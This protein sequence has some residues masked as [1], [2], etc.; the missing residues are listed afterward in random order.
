MRPAGPGI[1]VFGG[2]ALGTYLATLL[3]GSGADVRLVR[4][5]ASSGESFTV[6]TGQG[7]RVLPATRI[8]GIGHPPPDGFDLAVIAV[9]RFDSLQLT[10]QLGPWLAA[11]AAVLTVQNGLDA[12]L[13]FGAC[14]ASAFPGIAYASVHRN[15]SEVLHAGAEAR[16]I[17]PRHSQ[18]HS[19]VRVFAATLRA[20]GASVEFVQDIDRALWRK[21]AFVASYGGVCAASGRCAGEVRA[22]PD[23][24]L[25]VRLA[26]VEAAEIA[27]ASGSG[28]GH[29]SSLLDA[30][31]QLP[32]A[33]RPSMLV[34]M[35][36][37]RRL[38]TAW[39]S[40]TLIERGAK[41]GVRSPVHDWIA[42]LLGASGPLRQFA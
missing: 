7:R 9:K 38:E 34:D 2:G 33:G 4:R 24:A 13:D 10:K 3:F 29:L 36:H 30:F 18:E 26:M 32:W 6:A 41:S 19:A 14:T 1:A 23:L 37:G 8:L 27:E 21:L 25:L 16:L 22:S 28:V 42:T 17:L 5:H 15:E 12:H 11:D 31:A 20:A 40:G 39:L 35:Q